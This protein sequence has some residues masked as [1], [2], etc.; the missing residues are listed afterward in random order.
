[1]DKTKQRRIIL[2]STSPRRKE[3]IASLH[4][5]FEV[6]PSHADED[7]PPEWTPEQTVQELAMRKALAVYRGLEG[8]EQ[9]AVIVGSDTVVVLDGDILGKPVDE[10]DAER[11][12]S[13][14]QGRV[15]RVFTGV[16]CIDANNG[17]SMVQYRQT[18]VTM[19]ELSEATIRAY[20][21]TGEPSDKAGS[22]AIQGIGASLI[23]RV[24]GCYFNVV[25]LPLSLLSDMLDG[26][27][28]HV[29][30]RT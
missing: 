15:H 9:D 16:A 3:L 19:K 5:A 11:M 13:R 22:Y 18:D 30:P 23:D 20:V 12:L 28:I 17:Q 14:L 27:G 25:G 21:Q 6:I 7:T 24:E 10:A 4:L 29:L 1:M 2:A 8:R 26:F